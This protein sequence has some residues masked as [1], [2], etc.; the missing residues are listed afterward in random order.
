MTFNM[1]LFQ[2]PHLG[3]MQ[4]TEVRLLLTSKSPDGRQTMLL[5]SGAAT[6]KSPEL[7]R[8]TNSATNYLIL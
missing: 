5:N 1:L 6:S 4:A 7:H 8:A 3:A 2:S